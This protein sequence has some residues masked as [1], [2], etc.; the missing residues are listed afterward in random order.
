VRS[1]GVDIDY[2]VVNPGGKGT[3]VFLISGLNGARVSWGLQREA[4]SQNRPLILHDHRGTGKSAKPK[5]AYSVR[6]MAEDV[7]AVMDTLKIPKAH[8][9][10]SSTGGAIS[11]VLCIDHPD[12]VQSSA[13]VSSWPRCDAYFKRQ[14]TMR[15]RVLLEMGWEAYTRLSAITLNSPR[16]FT[17]HFEEIEKKENEAL[18]APPPAEIMA[19]RIDCI[20]AHDEWD[21][22]GRIQAPVLV[23]VARDDVTTPPYYSEQLVR[24][25]PGAVLRVFEDGGHFVYVARAREFNAAVLDFIRRNEPKASAGSGS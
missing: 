24:L 7:I 21:R 3:P 12:R 18:A 22:L 8:F 25:I 14:F 15:K 11:Q 5:G 6:L 16:F 20:I 4:F 17:E 2:E 1:G 23:L 9:V 10:G 13:I 19:E